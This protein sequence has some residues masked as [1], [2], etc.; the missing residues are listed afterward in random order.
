MGNDSLLGWAAAAVMA[1]VAAW[2]LQRHRGLRSEIRRVREQL[3]QHRE[4][5]SSEPLAVVVRDDELEHLAAEV[6]G[7]IDQYRRVAAEGR[8]REAR[9]RRE[10]ADLSHDL[11]T[12]LIAIRGYLQLLQRDG[13]AADTSPARLGTVL[14]RVDDLGRLVDDFFELSVLD[15]TD[16][17]LE[18]G[19]V[20]AT[21]VVTDALLGFYVPLQE[22]GIEPDL[23]LPSRPLVV[24]GEETALSRVVRNLV[25]NALTHST[26][27]LRVRLEGANGRAVL[28]V[29]NGAA[30]A[31]PEEVELI[32]E[33]FY[34]ADRARTGPHAGLGLSIVK[35]LVAQMHGTVRAELDGQ[36]L[37]IVVELSLAQQARTVGGAA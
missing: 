33:R 24:Q 3:E 31:R 29:A 23:V 9:L 32:F 7:S 8:A 20:D 37:R 12:P 4:A 28:V 11:K 27:G 30:D 21:Q 15:S 17:H 5:G 16:H 1:L 6:D 34:R 26:D 36:E 19:P 18:L 10:I 25:S 2:L 35:E 14:G 22:R 13:L